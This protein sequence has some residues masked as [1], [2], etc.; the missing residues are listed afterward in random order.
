MKR[1]IYIKKKIGFCLFKLIFFF[2]F[3]IIDLAHK[4][5]LIFEIRAWEIENI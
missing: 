5:E 3:H 4:R 2:N 1:F